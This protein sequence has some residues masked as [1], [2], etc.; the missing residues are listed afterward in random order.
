MMPQVQKLPDIHQI[1]K[2]GRKILEAI[3]P[4]LQ[5]K[6][7]ARFVAIDVDTGITSSVRRV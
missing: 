4:E 3:A 2:K 1:S 7:F 6:H 5:E